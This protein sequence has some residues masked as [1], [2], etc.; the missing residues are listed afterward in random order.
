MLPTPAQWAQMSWYAR[1]RLA[2]HR[3]LHVDKL[4]RQVFKSYRISQ[5]LRW[6]YLQRAEADRQLDADVARCATCGGWMI[7]ECR[8]PHVRAA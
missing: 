6:Y 4:E 7:G 8:V 3:R 2:N 5:A 1:Q